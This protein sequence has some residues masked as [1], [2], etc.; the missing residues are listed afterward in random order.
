[1][2][3]GSFFLSN[4]KK[5]DAAPCVYCASV[6]CLVGPDATRSRRR[7]PACAGSIEW[8]W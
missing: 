1:M 6:M 7:S 8:T 4:V 2:I 3:P 5:K